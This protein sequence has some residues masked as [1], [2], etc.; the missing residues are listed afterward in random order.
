MASCVILG[1]YNPY[2]LFYNFLI[3]Y[4]NDIPYLGA[5]KY[6]HPKLQELILTTPI[7]IILCYWLYRS[8]ESEGG[9]KKVLHINI[10]SLCLILKLLL[11]TVLKII[12]RCS[13]YS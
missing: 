4:I 11:I 12:P 9:F 13:K 10:E 6:L 5:T 3:P 7:I 8:V 1:D 2:A